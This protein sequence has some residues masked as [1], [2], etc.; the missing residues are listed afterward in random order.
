QRQFVEKINEQLKEL[1][2]KLISQSDLSNIETGKIPTISEELALVLNDLFSVNLGTLEATGSVRTTASQQN[3]TE[4]PEDQIIGQRFTQLREKQGLAIIELARLLKISSWFINDIEKGIRR[5]AK[6]YQKIFDAVQE[7][8]E[9]QWDIEWILT[10]QK[11]TPEIPQA[12]QVETPSSA[13]TFNLVVPG[14]QTSSVEMQVVEEEIDKLTRELLKER[15]QNRILQLNVQ[16]A[17]A[18]KEALERKLASLQAES[19]KLKTS[20]QELSSENQILLQQIA[21]LETEKKALQ[22]KY[23]E[24]ENWEK[25]FKELLQARP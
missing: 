10:G 22:D 24:L 5:H 11:V 19:E 15:T 17:L 13:E 12:A 20:N 2:L 25:R 14:P 3:Y 9:L 6:N 23:V 8:Q 4:T 21:S 7:N 16:E 1:G 18:E